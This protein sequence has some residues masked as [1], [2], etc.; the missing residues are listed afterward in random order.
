MA[1]KPFGGQLV[2]VRRLILE[3]PS[4]LTAIASPSTKWQTPNRWSECCRLKRKRPF[5]ASH[6][7]L[8]QGLN[9]CEGG[10]SVVAGS[11]DLCLH[12]IGG[13]VARVEFLRRSNR[14]ASQLPPTA[15][16]TPHLEIRH[17]A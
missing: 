16:Q 4:R 11:D 8:C 15:Q 10:V 12:E 9:F 5:P 14:R 7:L 6:N 13:V 1:A 2:A 3:L 17:G